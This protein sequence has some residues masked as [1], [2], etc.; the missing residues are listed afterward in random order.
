MAAVNHHMPP[1]RG[2]TEIRVHGV[3]GTPPESLLE[4]TGVSQITGDDTAGLYRGAVGVAGRTVE[5]YSWGGLTTRSRS[6]AFWILLL[7]F[8]MI[9]ISGWMVEPP[10]RDGG[11]VETSRRTLGTRLHESVVALVAVLATA[12]YVMW[13]ALLAMNALAF[14]CGAIDDCRSDRWYLD[15]LGAGF[16]DGAPGRR[17][18]T[19]LVIPLALLALF[20]GLGLLSRSRYDDYGEQQ[21][22]AVD[23]DAGQ[24]LLGKKEF[25]YTGRWQGQVAY[26]H[27]AVV[28]SL[29]SG[30][31]ARASHEFEKR[32]AVD[33]VPD[34]GMAVFWASVAVAVAAVAVLVATTFF[35]TDDLLGGTRLMAWVGRSV[36]ALSI[37]LLAVAVWLTWGL[38]VADSEL[39]ES[40]TTDGITRLRPVTDLWGFGWAPILLLVLAVASVGVFSV[41]QLWRWLAWSQVYLD[42]MSVVV[43]LA[44]VAFWEAAPV[45]AGIA[46]LAAAVVE[47]TQWVAR[48]SRPNPDYRPE[49]W[50]LGAFVATLTVGIVA[51]LLTRD[52]GSPYGPDWPRL[53]PLLAFAAML[54]LFNVVRLLTA[55]AVKAAIA[56]MAVPGTIA[57][58]GFLT[59]A[60]TGRDE[61]RYAAVGLAL[62]IVSV[63]WLAQQPFDGWRWNG[64]AGT[65]VLALSIIMGVFAG[66]ALRLADFLDRDGSVFAFRATAIYQW[67]TIGFVAMLGAGMVA[68]VVWVLLVYLG[69]PT[70]G[71]GAD[72]VDGPQESLAEGIRAADVTVTM[73]ALTIL[74]GGLALVAHLAGSDLPLMEWI[75]FGVPA[76]WSAIVDWATWITLLIVVTVFTLVRSGLRD[77]AARRRLGTLWDV[78]SFW[79]RNFHPFAPPAYASRAVPEMQARLIE[80]VSVAD[81]RTI[82]SAHSQGTVVAI[83][84]VASLPLDVR[85]R[86]RLV[87]HGSPLRRFYQ[88]FFPRYFPNT[89]L[90]RAATTLGPTD[91]IGDG[92]WLNYWRSTDPIG[93]PVFRGITARTG[94]PPPEVVAALEK[95]RTG[96]T[97]CPDFRLFDPVQ[98]G[99]SKFQIRTKVRGHP[100]YMADPAMSEAID[101]WAAVLGREHT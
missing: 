70:T 80:V 25:W 73:I 24:S 94:A 71:D 21:K 86:V 63:T 91:D 49:P 88:R 15:F 96:M 16:Y 27:L 77:P 93:D 56:V 84:A 92:G 1:N 38:K 9:N 66:G 58:A 50:R 47:A 17:V 65:A 35:T 29:L 85:R 4:Q 31:L 34:I 83:A 72:E 40:F 2:V 30:L 44:F 53:T 99:V 36:L 51:W 60:V 87:T 18:V 74:T 22:R 101:A 95:S 5:A 79:P 14:Q 57:A 45:V 26:V 75:D 82:V 55:G 3:G 10:R 97:D 62:V 7:P 23:D 11:A 42:Q 69:A 6:R 32:F 52:A 68:M 98:S 89:L 41:V 48:R 100:G 13:A 78:A 54:V 46:A 64:P 81:G 20:F 90:T 39:V 33:V 19:A 76:E 37:I 61:W 8:S 43:V 28:L 12:M 59:A 67:L